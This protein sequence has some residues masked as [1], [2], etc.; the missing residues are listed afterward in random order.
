MTARRQEQLEDGQRRVIRRHCSH[1]SLRSNSSSSAS[2]STVRMADTRNADESPTE[3]DHDAATCLSCTRRNVISVFPRFR[4]VSN[5]LLTSLSRSSQPKAPAGCP[6]ESGL[7]AT[8]GACHAAAAATADTAAGTE[9]DRAPKHSSS[10]RKDTHARDPP[11]RVY[12]THPTM[13]ALCLGLQRDSQCT[14]SSSSIRDG[15]SR[16][17]GPGDRCPH[18]SIIPLPAIPERLAKGC[19]LLKTTSRGVHYRDFRLDIAQQRITWNSRKK[20]K[21][22]H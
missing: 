1:G 7:K 20:K 19:P 3:I 4:K 10:G 21:L 11:I 2:S 9:A 14:C 6:V 17:A 18:H 5:R 15:V 22:A 16:G 12:P 8:G 13:A